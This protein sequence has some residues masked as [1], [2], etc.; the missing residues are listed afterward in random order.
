MMRFERPLT[1]TEPLQSP[2]TLSVAPFG[3]AFTAAWR[4]ENTRTNEGGFVTVTTHGSVVSVPQSMNGV[5]VAAT[6]GVR[7]RV[8]VVV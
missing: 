7:V 6:V 2:S 1:S 5:A 3:A 4:L 8:G